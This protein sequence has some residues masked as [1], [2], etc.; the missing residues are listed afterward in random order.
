[1][2]TL[3]NLS[4]YIEKIGVE[5]FKEEMRKGIFEG[6]KQ[7]CNEYLSTGSIPKLKYFEPKFEEPKDT[8]E[9]YY[10]LYWNLSVEKAQ[11]IY[12]ESKRQN[13]EGVTFV[14]EEGQEEII[15]EEII[16][17]NESTENT[18]TSKVQN[19]QNS[20]TVEIPIIEH[21]EEK[22]SILYARRLESDLSK[23]YGLV[24]FTEESCRKREQQMKELQIKLNA[25]VDMYTNNIQNDMHRKTR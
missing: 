1:M 10:W 12:L 15:E 14:P 23:L 19:T 4:K 13:E 24:Y 18:S 3:E 9:M 21:K 6:S 7:C 2:E 20:E 25:A 5:R 16:P 17:L 22:E 8:Y 11:V